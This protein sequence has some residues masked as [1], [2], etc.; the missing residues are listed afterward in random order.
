MPEPAATG[1]WKQ[2]RRTRKELLEAAARLLKQGRAP[3]LEE[4]ADEAL[5][6][7]ATAYRYFPS[8][9]AL[10]VEASVDLAMPDPATFFAGQPAE[11]PVARLER[12]DI[13]VH[14]MIAANEVPL[15][16]MLANSVA[17]RARGQKPGELPNR[18]NRRTPL[19][20]AAL[21]PARDRFKPADLEALTA[22]LALIIGT[23]AMVVFRDVLQLDD[24]KARRVR[25]WAIRTL[26][27]AAL[28]D[29][30]APL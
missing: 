6:S 13:A 21:A 10:L 18:Q 16:L 1:R 26:C 17:Q 25:H 27:S 30:K 2:K 19:I 14:D 3:S 5:V 4:A 29:V 24:A 28:K 9:E 22:T 20:E 11:G 8:A 7:R 15:R 12:A 23:E